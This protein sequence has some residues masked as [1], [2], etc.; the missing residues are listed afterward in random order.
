MTVSLEKCWRGRVKGSGLE[1]IGSPSQRWA[2]SRCA[3]LH[4]LVLTYHTLANTGLKSLNY[5][6]R[7]RTRFCSRGRTFKNKR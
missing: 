2:R 4:A 1:T 6:S 7:R 3:E 5:R